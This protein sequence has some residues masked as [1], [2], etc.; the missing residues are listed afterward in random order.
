M[1]MYDTV[2]VPCPKCGAKAEFQSKSGQ[3][4]LDVYE[5]DEA[6]ADVLYDV[7]RH[8]PATCECGTKFEVGFTISPARVNSVWVT[9]HK[10]NP[11]E[12]E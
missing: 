2:M 8:A 7:N 10:E 12:D 11:D 5:L 4:R 9:E 1:G 6:P 3:C